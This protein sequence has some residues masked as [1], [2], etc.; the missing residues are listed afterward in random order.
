[1]KKARPGPGRRRRSRGLQRQ[2]SWRNWFL[3]GD[4]AIGLDRQREGLLLYSDQES[5]DDAEVY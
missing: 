1:M 3:G 2:E 5:G 4:S